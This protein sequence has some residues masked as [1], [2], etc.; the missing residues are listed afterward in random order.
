MFSRNPCF[1]HERFATYAALVSFRLC[2]V[3]MRSAALVGRSWGCLE[4]SCA[5]LGACLVLSWSAPG[6]VLVLSLV[7]LA[8]MK[9]FLA[10][11]YFYPPL[12]MCNHCFYQLPFF[13]PP[14]RDLFWSLCFWEWVG[15]GALPS[16]K[17]T[18]GL[19]AS[20]INPSTT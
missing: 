11:L 19:A 17:Y 2:A 8:L 7:L 13:D 6:S 16:F 1:K 14:K 3:R 5:S 10:F 12:V 18:G 20:C 15:F 9:P 4:Q